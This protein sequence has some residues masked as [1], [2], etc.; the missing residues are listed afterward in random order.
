NCIGTSSVSKNITFVYLAENPGTVTIPATTINVDGTPIT[1]AAKNFTI[2]PPSAS[3]QRQ[4]P[5]QY[6]YDPWD[7]LLGRL[8]EY[9]PFQPA[10]AAQPTRTES[11]VSANDLII[12]VTMSKKKVY[13]NEAV[14]ATIKLYT[15]HDISNF[16]PKVMPQFEGFL[17]E[18]L[19]VSQQQAQLEHFRGENYYSVILKRC[20]LFPEKTGRLTIN[21]G[22]Y[23]VTLVTYDM[24]S[25]GFYQTSQRREHPVVAH[26]SSITVDVTPLPLPAPLGFTNAVGSFDIKASLSSEK[27]RTNEPAKYTVTI[28]GTGNLSHLYEPRLVF[29]D[30]FESYEPQSNSDTRFNGSTLQGTYT[31]DYT[32]VPT[33]T[34]SYEI[35]G[36]DFSF[37]NPATGQYETRS[38]APIKVN[39]AKGL[40][41]ASSSAAFDADELSDIRHITPV[42]PDTLK[43]RPD[44]LVKKTV[45]WLMYALGILI[46]A[47]AIFVYRKHIKASADLAG[48]R[49]RRA[50]RVA[51]TRLKKA[52]AAM[53]AHRQEDF[54]ASLSAALWGYLGD[55]LKMPA[56]TLTRENI[57]DTLAGRGASPEIV[58]ELIS[59]LD[60][61]EMARFTP[62]HSDAEM[63]TIY[64]RAASIIN[65]LEGLKLDRVRQ[66]DTSSTQTSRYGDL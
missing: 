52:Y 30:G 11:K 53:N 37:F 14:I 34:G 19:P 20:L 6:A 4:R 48:T 33:E 21:S 46:L 54:Y 5:Q 64:E 41:S 47:V 42:N 29:P 60:E 57:H 1:V 22:E 27:L 9:D 55:K 10:P 2:L 56:S 13:E 63:S 44:F 61:A 31:V 35:P 3:A 24:V 43:R 8:D 65:S 49:T 28:S 32:I 58:D 12:T 51:A 16:Q 40:P 38:V 62:N 23:D 66:A 17:S 59:V 50:R 7:D 15:K 25:N 26:S 18:E 45:Y 39:V 36:W